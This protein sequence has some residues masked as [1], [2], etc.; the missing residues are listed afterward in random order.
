[1]NNLKSWSSIDNGHYRVGNKTFINKIEALVESSVVHQFPQWIFHN[2]TYS[3]FDWTK[4]PVQ[5]LDQLYAQRARELRAS[6]DHLVLH[7]SGGADSTNILETFIRHKI[8]LDEVLLRG[9]IGI[10][11]KDKNETAAWN[12]HAENWFNAWP[13]ANWIKDNHYPNLKITVVDVTEYPKSYFAKNKYWF[14]NPGFNNLT[15]G[16]VW[17]AD[18]D[19]VEKSLLNLSDRGIK[20]AHIL[21]LEKPLMIYDNGRFKAKFIDTAINLIASE[22]C[23]KYDVPYH[24]EPFYWSKTTAPIIIKQCHAIK[25][26]IKQHKIDPKIFKNSS[27][28]YHEWMAKIIYDRTLPNYFLHE[29]TVGPIPAIDHYFFQDRDADYFKNFQHGIQVLDEIIDPYWKDY[30]EPGMFNLRGIESK[31]Y[32]LG[33]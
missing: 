8:H 12:Q 5:N 13:L 10:S 9:T 1:M 20:V 22:R 4:E 25:R 30:Y 24:V 16:I 28:D 2:E 19:I 18:Y 26:F 15:P 21:G 7:F 27:R 11:K 33:D 23:M 3:K 31:E 29:K 17:R 32:D 14:E 6:Y